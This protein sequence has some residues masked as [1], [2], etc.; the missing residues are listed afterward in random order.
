MPEASSPDGGIREATCDEVT[1]K[2]FGL[3]LF[4]LNA[5]IGLKTTEQCEN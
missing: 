1:E 2:A 4:G 5:G 3:C